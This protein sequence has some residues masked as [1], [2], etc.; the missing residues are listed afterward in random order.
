MPEVIIALGANLGQPVEALRSAVQALGRRSEEHTSELQ[1]GT[2]RF[3][4]TSPVESSGPD[5]VNAAVLVETAL[6]PMALLRACQAIE[7]AHGRVRPAGVVNAPRT[8][9]LDVIAY[10]GTVSDDPVL[11]LPHPRM[12]ERLFVLVPIA[13]LLPDWR[14]PDGR[15]VGEAVRDV[16]EAHPDQLIRPLGPENM[17]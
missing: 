10:E 17:A 9:D 1:L 3:Y 2:S 4:T 11:T 14:L 6:E 7:N 8:L 5:Y 13:D 12:H 15:T 16:R